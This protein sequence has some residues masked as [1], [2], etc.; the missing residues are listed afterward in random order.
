MTKG[1]NITGHVKFI[2]TP[3]DGVGAENKSQI[4]SISGDIEAQK[5]GIAKEAR[6]GGEEAGVGQ[7]QE[8]AV[9]NHTLDPLIGV[10]GNVI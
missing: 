2:I 5:G 7:H 1:V 3:E 9:E 8:V 10:A 6:L 4:Q